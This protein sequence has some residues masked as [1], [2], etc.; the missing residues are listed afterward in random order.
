LHQIR[1]DVALAPYDWTWNVVAVLLLLAGVWCL[2]TAR[3]AAA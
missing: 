1:Y 3:T 2:R